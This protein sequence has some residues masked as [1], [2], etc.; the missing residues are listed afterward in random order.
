MG[1][2]G[3]RG[4]INRE[5]FGARKRERNEREREVRQKGVAGNGRERR[6]A[7]VV[8]RQVTGKEGM[9]EERSRLNVGREERRESRG[10]RETG[11]KE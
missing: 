11:M 6:M 10:V 5:K 9:T 2:G 7:E 8:S 1:R 3:V 4:F